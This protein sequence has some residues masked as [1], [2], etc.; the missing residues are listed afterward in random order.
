MSV[1]LD[2]PTFKPLVEAGFLKKGTVLQGI[3]NGYYGCAYWTEGN[4]FGP[5]NKVSYA[6]RLVFEFDGKTHLTSQFVDDLA[7]NEQIIWGENHIEGVLTSGRTKLP[8][9]RDLVNMA[10]NLTD[11]LRR[12]G[13]LPKINK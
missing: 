1:R 8:S 7:K 6:I 5:D 10:D 2:S 13:L 12:H 11:K 9:Q 4:P 3:Y